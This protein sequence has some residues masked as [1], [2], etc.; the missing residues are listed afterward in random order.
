MS[1]LILYCWRI[2]WGTTTYAAGNKPAAAR[3]FRW[4][5]PYHQ[6]ESESNL[7]KATFYR[8][9]RLLDNKYLLR[10]NW[11]CK[12]TWT[13][14]VSPWSKEISLFS[15]PLKVYAARAWKVGPP[16]DWPAWFCGGGRLDCVSRSKRFDVLEI[17]CSMWYCTSSLR[18]LKRTS[19][20]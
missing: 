9:Y 20:R 19:Q 5:S 4:T 10:L 13:V 6:A 3:P 12:W 18:L 11:F 16:R 15:S 1:T 17:E 14:I 7:Q 8:F 2:G